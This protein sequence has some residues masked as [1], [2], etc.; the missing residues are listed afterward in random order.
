MFVASYP[1]AKLYPFYIK[2]ED[3]SY[4]IIYAQL[5]LR[6]AFVVA[7]R[8]VRPREGRASRRSTDC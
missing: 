2:L 5:I 6:V 1:I 4:N 8:S 7:S 3:S